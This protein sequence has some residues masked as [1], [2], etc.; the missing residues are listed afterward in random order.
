MASNVIFGFQYISG[1]NNKHHLMIPKSNLCNIYTRQASGAKYLIKNHCAIVYH[2]LVSIYKN[3][4]SSSKCIKN[5]LVN[6]NC[7]EY[8]NVIH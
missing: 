4:S 3:I 6:W 2:T 5:W 1:K 8:R 7:N